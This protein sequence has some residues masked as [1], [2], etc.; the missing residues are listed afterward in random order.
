[1]GMA[2][3]QARFLSLTARKSNVEY[4]GQQVNQQRTALSNESANLYNKLTSIEVPTPPATS[5]YYETVYT[6]KTTELDNSSSESTEYTLNSIYTMPDGTYANLSYMAY[7][8]QAATTSAYSGDINSTYDTATGETKYS[9]SLANGVV[10]DATEYKY[11]PSEAEV[12]LDFSSG[13]VMIAGEE[14]KL[15]DTKDQILGGLDETG[16]YQ[17]AYDVQDLGNGQYALKL[18][19]TQDKQNPEKFNCTIAGQTYEATL[20]SNGTYECIIESGDP[21]GTSYSADVSGKYVS[22]NGNANSAVS[23]LGSDFTTY[24]PQGSTEEMFNQPI[25]AYTLNGQTYFVTAAEY[26]AGEGTYFSSSSYVQS[27]GHQESVSYPCIFTTSSTG[28]YETLTVTDDNGITH[29][30]SLDVQTVQDEEAY[31]QAMLDYEYEQAQYQ[32][33]VQD[34]NAKT[35]ALQQED[36]TLELRLKQLDTEQNAIATEMDAVQKVIEDNV[37]STFKTFA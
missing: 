7:N 12:T 23:Y 32:K 4:E 15:S 2:A 24:T 6:F 22:A 30:F 14:F 18:S 1:M 16:K 33:Q 3:S 5:D 8:W 13:S 28:R 20:Q 31:Q 10:A 37:E 11:Q 9:I 19:V 17:Y 29:Q 25:L 27:V 36:R 34:I 26:Q 35:E 21:D